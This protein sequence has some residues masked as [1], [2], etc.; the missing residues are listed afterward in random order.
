M[1]VQGEK[2]KEIRI[3]LRLTVS[4]WCYNFSGG[5]LNKSLPIVNF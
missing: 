2:N 5:D 1:I 3:W 4:L